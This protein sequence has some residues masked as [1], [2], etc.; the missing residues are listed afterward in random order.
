MTTAFLKLLDMH[1][2]KKVSVLD[3]LVAVL[4]V[5]VAF[6]AARLVTAYMRRAFK[7]KIR[8]DNLE[9]AAKLV[10]WSIVVVAVIYALGSLGFKLSGLM[11]AGG[12][13]GVVIGFASQS[14]VG[15]LISGIF[16]M[17]ERPIKIGDQVSINDYAGFVEDIRI[18]STTL[19]TF[20]GLFVRIPNEKIFTAPIVN[21]VNH[22]VRRIDYTVGIRYSDDADKAI[23]VIKHV[24]DDYPFALKY[25]EPVVFVETLGDNCVTIAVRIWAPVAEWY[26]AKKELLWRIKTE[27]EREGMEIP[28]PQRVVWF[29]NELQT[30]PV[31]TRE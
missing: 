27:L 9:I 20:D 19:R 29:G 12:I 16:L 3:G 25:P 14:I 31:G 17:I 26:G 23:A 24:I 5:A 8:K 18:I 21:Y 15:N 30:K 13:A 10:N 6:I 11:V 2:Y 7:D 22:I 4:A 1:L 28:F